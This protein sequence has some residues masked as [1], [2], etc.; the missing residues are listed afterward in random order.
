MKKKRS[1]L[2]PDELMIQAKRHRE[3]AD[4]FEALCHQTQLNEFA[5]QNRIEEFVTAP[6]WV[7]G[8]KVRFGVCEMLCHAAIAQDYVPR[9]EAFMQRYVVDVPEEISVE[10]EVEDHKKKEQQELEKRCQ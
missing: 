8:K 1:P 7:T 2:T 9:V 5:T 4:V 6:P 10:Q 3:I